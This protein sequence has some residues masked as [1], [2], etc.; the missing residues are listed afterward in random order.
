M[1]QPWWKGAT[2]YEVYIRSFFDSTGD[3]IGDLYGIASKLRYIQRLGVDAIW[4]TP[5]FR[6][7]MNDFG[8]DV[9]DYES[10]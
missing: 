5:F 9:E 3:G 4:I 2:I 1:T 7:P 6:S 8:Y 10:V